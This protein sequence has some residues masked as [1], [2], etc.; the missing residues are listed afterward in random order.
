MVGSMGFYT[1]R[2]SNKSTRPLLTVLGLGEMSESFND[3]ANKGI[4]PTTLIL[5]DS[6][7]R[8][9]TPGVSL[10]P[11]NAS[12]GS[13]IASMKEKCRTIRKV[14]YR[15]SLFVGAK[16]TESTEGNYRSSSVMHAIPGG[17]KAESQIVIAADAHR[18]YDDY[19][20]YVYYPKV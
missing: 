9:E 1:V 13:E 3:L 8:D 11:W 18:F 12:L 17:A 20:R 7:G 6:R 14:I 16:S 10:G 5:D 19:Y 4:A 2:L 15:H